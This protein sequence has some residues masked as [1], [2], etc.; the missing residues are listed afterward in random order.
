M[1][2]LNIVLYRHTGE[3]REVT[4]RKNQLNIITGA[5]DR[6]KTAVLQIL[7]YV[8]G[9]TQCTIPFK[10]RINVAWF[11]VTVAIG[12]NKIFIA[13]KSPDAS[14]SANSEI[15]YDLG[16]Q[17]EIPA[18]K[19][20][21]GN[22]NPENLAVFLGNAIG[23]TENIQGGTRTVPATIRHALVFSFQGQS[24]IANEHFLFHRQSDYWL[25]QDLKAVF[26][27]FTGASQ[28][29]AIGIR[30][31]L[32]RIRRR[33]KLWEKEKLEAERIASASTPRAYSLAAEAQTVGLIS[34]RELPTNNHRELLNILA[35]VMT[36]SP[37]RESPQKD[38]AIDRLQHERSTLLSE[39]RSVR[40]QL[41][42]ANSYVNDH[43]FFSAEANLQSRRLET[44]SVF[45]GTATA[46][47]CP[48]CRS[49]LGPEATQTTQLRDAIVQLRAE[50]GAVER[51]RSSVEEMVTK[52]ESREAELRNQLELNK[53]AL[54]SLLGQLQN[55]AAGRDLDILRA[56]IV[57]R[58]QLYLETAHSLER[59]SDEEMETLKGRAKELEQKLGDENIALTLDA[60]LQIISREIERNAARLEL[61]FSTSPLR[62]DMETLRLEAATP[63][64]PVRMVDFGGG[65]NYMGYHIAVHMALH[66]FFIGQARPVPRFLVLD[67]PTQ[68][69]YPPDL[70]EGS[71]VS[72]DD[73]ADEDRMKARRL[74]IWL[75]N[76]LSEL[77]SMQVIVC[78]HADI[79][80]PWFQA[81][82]VNK[83]RG[84]DALVP[85]EWME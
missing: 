67:Q 9:A 48:F 82:V 51:N 77:K 10:I 14:P 72:V 53:S 7:E 19:A 57:G 17:V 44:I 23:I 45:E 26:P 49:S 3:T 1:Q 70:P 62:L 13:R 43:V 65:S 69:F 35:P 29:D 60:Q 11:A 38:A 55:L 16:V 47:A 5:P 84:R 25:T 56:Q 36:W 58:V 76:Y 61:A 59:G 80:E 68:V 74:F 37:T 18:L 2:I 39:L 30:R 42:T 6:G 64:G 83:W 15:Y 34:D 81:R 75:D 22:M 20:L 28:E 31:E 27:Y 66:R 21:H 4:F 63:R 46:D 8:L 73:F 40:E 12:D 85:Y 52:L 79:Q 24:E 71:D 41:N 32:I 78:D 33:L 50:L 54:N